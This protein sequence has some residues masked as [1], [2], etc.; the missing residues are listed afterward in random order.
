MFDSV[1]RRLLRGIAGTIADL[2]AQLKARVAKLIGGRRSVSNRG[3]LRVLRTFDG[4]YL[5][6][7]AEALGSVTGERISAK[8][9]REYVIGEVTLSNQLYHQA[10]ETAARVRRILAEHTRYAH[11]AR[12]LALDLY[13]GYGFRERETLTPRVRLPKYL[14]DAILNGELDALLAR[15]QAANLKTPA[16]RAA[17]LQALDRILKGAGQGA[18]DRALDVAVQERYRYFAN[19]IAQTELARAQNEQ[20]AREIMA[21]DA[22]EVV[23]FRM[24]ASHPAVDICDAFAHTDRYG[25]GPGCYPKALAPRPPLHPHC[26][27][28]CVPRLDLKVKDATAKPDAI[29]AYLRGLDPKDAAKVAGS[30]ARRDEILN[31]GDWMAMLNRGRPEAYRIGTAGDVM[32]RGSSGI[33][34]LDLFLDRVKRLPT[35]GSPE[36]RLAQ[37]WTTPDLYRSHVKRRLNYGHITT[38]REMAEKTFAA[39]SRAQRARLSPGEFPV[40][41]IEDGAWSIILDGAGRIKTAYPLEP[42][43]PSFTDNQRRLGHQVDDL[44]LSKRVL[45]IFARLFGPH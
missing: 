10:H 6:A 16:L 22:I 41:E 35:D 38:E 33:P 21:D 5:D 24:S 27:C 32:A 45:E 2:A 12:K 31:G 23:Q 28:G 44:N 19:R 40:M 8:E 18:I 43:R 39:L 26:L 9:L 29:A 4:P 37:L 3:L 25:L 36:S 20:I 15:I 17:Y 13:E 42:G 7:M 1:F 14:D 11:D 30:K 34:A